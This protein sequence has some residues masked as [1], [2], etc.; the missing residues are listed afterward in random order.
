MT[1]GEYLKQCRKEKGMSIKQAA[2]AAGISASYLSSMERGS[3]TAPPFELLQTLAEVLGLDAEACCRLYDLAAESK[4]PPALADD[5]AA[6]INRYPVLRSML[7]CAMDSQLTEQ[8]WETIM[9]YIKKNF[10]C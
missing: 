7:R 9:S 3:R 5:L 4:Q 1:F 10:F 2:Q 8:D 6:Y